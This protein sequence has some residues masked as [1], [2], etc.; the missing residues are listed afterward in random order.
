MS[1]ASVSFQILIHRCEKGYTSFL[2]DWPSMKRRVIDF[3]SN[4]FRIS[5]IE[6]TDP[7]TRCDGFEN[8]FSNEIF[9]ASDK[10]L[11]IA[12]QANFHTV[13]KYM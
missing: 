2:L 8:E 6:R 1:K 9:L 12:S 5:S 3:F 4:K 10:I 13:V 11:R 7:K